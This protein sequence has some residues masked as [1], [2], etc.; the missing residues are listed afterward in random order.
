MA[1]LTLTV[2]E[3]VA[4]QAKK[5]AKANNTTVSAMFSRF[6]ESLAAMEGQ[7][8]KLGPLTRRL[9]G[10]AKL[11]PDKGYKDLL[12]GALAKKYGAGR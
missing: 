7:P 1:K 5:L 8:A 3:T 2:K 9:S 6:I 11:P 4:A 12:A 10:V